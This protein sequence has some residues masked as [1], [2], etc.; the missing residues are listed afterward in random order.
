MWA[1]HSHTLALLTH[2]T[3]NKVELRWNKIKQGAFNEIKPIVSRVT[4]SAYPDFNEDSKIHTN[5][6]NLQLGAVI[7][8]DGKSIT[9]YSRKLTDYHKRYTVTEK[10]L[11][12]II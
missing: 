4:L 11:L 12:S 2:I 6:S 7:N 1:R 8:H 10:D 9:F 3:Y 5:A